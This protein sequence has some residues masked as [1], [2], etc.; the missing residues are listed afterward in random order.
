LARSLGL[1]HRDVVPG[2]NAFLPT[3]V[4]IDP[5]DNRVLWAHAEDD[6]RVRLGSDAVLA[7]IDAALK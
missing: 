7:A 2:K 6:L 3:K 5:R 1:V 4:L